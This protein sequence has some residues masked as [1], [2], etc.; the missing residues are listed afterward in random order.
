MSLE[1]INTNEYFL[2]NNWT[3]PTNIDLVSPAVEEFMTRLK[4]AGWDVESDEVINFIHVVFREALINAIAHGNLEVFVTETNTE[5]LGVLAKIE[6]DRNPTDKKVYVD[7]KIDEKQ[8][9]VVI[10]DEGKGFDITKVPDPT[11]PERLL[12]RSG[13][14]LF[15][16]RSFADSVTHNSAGNEVTMVKNKKTI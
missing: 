3:L 8:V 1:A 6:Q 13:R 11:S 2:G 5:E 16:M 12:E 10:R 9:V 4:D 7:I 15:F 14:G